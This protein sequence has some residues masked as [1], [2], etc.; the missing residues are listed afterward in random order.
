MTEILS[1]IISE[2]IIVSQD[3]QIFIKSKNRQPPNLQVIFR[4]STVEKEEPSDP[5]GTACLSV[6][7]LSSF[8]FL[9]F[10]KIIW[11]KMNEFDQNAKNPAFIQM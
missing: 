9:C 5:F 4:I 8:S 7:L 1:K 3:D 10:F 6:W 11:A 2:E